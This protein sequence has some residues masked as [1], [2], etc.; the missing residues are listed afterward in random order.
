MPAFETN[1]DL[2]Y[3]SL[4]IFISCMTILTSLLLVKLIIIISNVQSI[5]KSIKEVTSLLN[6]YAWKPIEVLMHLKNF[7]IKHVKK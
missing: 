7:F 2:L 6:E 4:T 1:L 5:V 3:F